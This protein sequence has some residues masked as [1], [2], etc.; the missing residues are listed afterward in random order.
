MI[1]TMDFWCNQNNNQLIH[2][3]HYK[4]QIHTKEKGDEIVMS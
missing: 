3:F 1:E 2:Q 4:E